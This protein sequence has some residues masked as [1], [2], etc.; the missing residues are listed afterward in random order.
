MLYNSPTVSI[1][2]FTTMLMLKKQLQGDTERSLQH[3]TNLHPQD[4]TWFQY[5]KAVS[6]T[7]CTNN[8]RRTSSV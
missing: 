5:I 7:N 2:C 1:T 4:D 8:W 6:A 3:I